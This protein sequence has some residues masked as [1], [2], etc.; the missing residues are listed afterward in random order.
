M[1]EAKLESLVRRGIQ[2]LFTMGLPGTPSPELMVGTVTVWLDV[3]DK[4][5]NWT[6]EDEPR[7]SA[8][9]RSLEHH[10][11]RWPLPKNFLEAV[12][13]K[14]LPPALQH[15]LTE[16]DRERAQDAID[17]IKTMATKRLD[18]R[19]V[20]ERALTLNSPGSYGHNLALETLEILDRRGV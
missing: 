11:E 9:F 19:K 6:L 2:R 4:H 13:R 5:A 12:P 7:F 20:W 15:Q 18:P 10:S 8:A 3:I 16:E 17:S 1:L 14:V